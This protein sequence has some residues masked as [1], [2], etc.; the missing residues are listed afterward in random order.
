MSADIFG[1]RLLL[2]GGPAWHNVGEVFDVAEKLTATQGAIRAGIDFPIEKWQLQAVNTEGQTVL[3]NKYAV[4]RG[5]MDNETEHQIL[6]TVGEKWTPIQALDIASK[7]DPLSE[8]YPVETVGALGNGEKIFFSLDAGESKIAQEDHHLYYLVTDHR[9]GG[10]ALQ[11]AFTPVRVVCQNTLIYGLEK[12]AIKVSLPHTGNIDADSTWYMN[13][14]A[15][16]NEAKDSVTEA[17]N[18]LAE[19]GPVSRTETDKIINSAY[20]TSRTNRMRL[21][22][23]ISK[24]SIPAKVWSKLLNDRKDE[25][26]LFENRVSR[27]DQFRNGAKDRLDQ[28]NQDFPRL[29]NTPWAVWQAVCE[30][31]D[32][33]KGH[34]D[35]LGSAVF[36][37]RAQ[38]KVRAYNMAQQ[39]ARMA[40]R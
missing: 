20:K 31:E 32:Y 10:G 5:P 30:T 24:D 18:F 23:T 33:R 2:R 27:T 40:V 3:T 15:Q 6:G 7:L 34:A 17:M 22:D 26:I 35:S 29:A 13:L 25:Q 4:V 12:S 16:M 36:G 14:L 39:V 8:K 38:T 11:I 21:G 1:D 28:F 37:D 19:V 9:D